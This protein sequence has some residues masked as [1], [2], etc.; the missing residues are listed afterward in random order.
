MA[1]SSGS[2]DRTKVSFE[3][4]KDGKWSIHS[5]MIPTRALS[6]AMKELKAQPDIIRNVSVVFGK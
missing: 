6:H 3:W 5:P 4:F 2:N 1:R